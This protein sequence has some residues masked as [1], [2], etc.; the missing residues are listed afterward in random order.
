MGL[1]PGLP[2]VRTALLQ[3]RWYFGGPAIFGVMS[4]CYP[5][6]GGAGR[7][8]LTEGEAWNRT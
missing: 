8:D 7:S 6:N 1:P 4:G 2:Q 5:G 3:E